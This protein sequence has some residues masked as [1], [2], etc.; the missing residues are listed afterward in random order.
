M[1]RYGHK[2]MPFGLLVVMVP[3]WQPVAPWTAHTTTSKTRSW[4]EFITEAT[5]R[6]IITTMS[7]SLRL[8]LPNRQPSGR[9]RHRM[10]LNCL[11]GLCPGR[12]PEGDKHVFG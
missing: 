11:R 5:A 10:H 12:R 6:V 3:C 1:K 8:R 4:A 2:H 9:P 7:S